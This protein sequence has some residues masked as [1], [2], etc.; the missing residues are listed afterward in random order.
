VSSVDDE[1]WCR[2]VEEMVEISWDRLLRRGDSMR[3]F[4]NEEQ[5]EAWRKLLRA[6][7]RADGIPLRT[8]RSGLRIWARI[9]DWKERFPERWAAMQAESAEWFRTHSLFDPVPEPPSGTVHD[10]RP[11]DGTGPGPPAPRVP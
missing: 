9:P 8:G 3:D 7:A 2:R 5:G 6:Q 11:T 1:L 4:A 10:F